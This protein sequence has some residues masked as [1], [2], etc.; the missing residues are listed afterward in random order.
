MKFLRLIVAASTCCA[1]MSC[2]GF[3]TGR[4]SAKLMP[5]AT[6][7]A[8]QLLVQ[9]A[10]RGVRFDLPADAKGPSYNSDDY[11]ASRPTWT[12]AHWRA[13]FVYGNGGLTEFMKGDRCCSLDDKAMH[14]QV[15]VG[16]Y[17]YYGA[18]AD[19]SHVE[20][21]DKVS[22]VQVTIEPNGLSENEALKV[23][24]SIVTSWE[25]Q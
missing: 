3:P 20:S 18:M 8:T 13:H 2:A 14:R 19:I 10:A 4:G 6:S 22:S 11:Y 21:P 23:I 7:D 1:I 24:A 5:C 15:C 25:Q 9:S 16:V 12:G 17:M